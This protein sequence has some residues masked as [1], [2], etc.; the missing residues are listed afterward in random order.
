MSECDQ[1]HK[2]TN[3]VKWR[4][5]ERDWVC[6]DCYYGTPTGEEGIPTVKTFEPYFLE[7]GPIHMIPNTDPNKVQHPKTADLDKVWVSSPAEER[8]YYKMLGIRN[9]ERNEK[10][11]GITAELKDR[12][13]KKVYFFG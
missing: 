8:K 7:H 10:I 9:L 3:R 4:K 6:L 1:C 12:P 13:T 2:E 11:L 5:N